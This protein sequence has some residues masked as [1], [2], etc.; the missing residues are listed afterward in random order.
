MKRESIY[1]LC[2][3]RLTMPSDHQLLKLIDGGEERQTF[4]STDL[5]HASW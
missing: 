2:Q 4:G 3:M 1:K 5:A